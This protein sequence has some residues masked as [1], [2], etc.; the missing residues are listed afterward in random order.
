MNGTF[1][2]R[3]GWDGTGRDGAEEAQRIIL[4]ESLNEET[5]FENKAND[6]VLCSFDLAQRRRWQKHSDVLST[7]MDGGGGGRGEK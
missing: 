2:G 1:S 4:I 7:L 3:I 5:C 6:A